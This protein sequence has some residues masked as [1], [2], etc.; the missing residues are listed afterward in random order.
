ME[1]GQQYVK[2]QGVSANCLVDSECNFLFDFI[3]L[4]FLLLRKTSRDGSAAVAH[5]WATGCQLNI[6]A[7]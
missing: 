6:G 5:T 2:F 3:E 7:S 1:F 4:T